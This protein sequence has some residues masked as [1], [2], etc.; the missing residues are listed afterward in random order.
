MKK[1][2]YGVLG[3]LMVIPVVFAVTVVQVKRGRNLV[4]DEMK[5]KSFPKLS[6]IDFVKKL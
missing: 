4:Q 1:A 6:P 3:V 2:L 5:S